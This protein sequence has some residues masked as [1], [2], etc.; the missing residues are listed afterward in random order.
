MLNHTATPNPVN[1]HA[2]QSPFPLWLQHAPGAEMAAQYGYGTTALLAADIQ[3]AI[4]D[5]IP[6]QEKLIKLMFDKPAIL[7]NSPKE[8]SWFE[9]EIPRPALEVL[10]GQGSGATQTIPLT[11]GGSNYISPNTLVHLPSGR[12]AIVTAVDTTAN[13]ITVKAANGSAVLPSISAGQII[14]QGFAPIAD[15]Q[16]FFS[17]Y[18]RLE[19]VEYRNWFATG[20]RARRWTTLTALDYQNNGTTEYFDRDAS[21]LWKMVYEDLFWIFV[22]AEKGQY[23]ITVP[24]GSG[25]TNAGTYKAT[26]GDGFYTFMVKNGAAHS[27]STPAS[28]EADFKT[29]AFGTNH[30]DVDGVR[31]VLGTPRMLNM[32]SDVWKDPVHYAPNDTIAS[33]DLQL[34]HFGAMKFVPLPVHHFESRANLLNGFDKK[35]IVIDKDKIN[36]TAI[37]GREQISANNTG[38]LHKSNGGY[39]DFIDYFIDYNLSTQVET[40]KGH[41]W[42]DMVGV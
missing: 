15:G 40:V 33:L 39:N 24:A 17:N 42:I 12:Q 6:K 10:T 38:S 7:K 25:M 31:Y 9:D 28:L 1:P 26:V 22:N 23:D 30:K 18:S 3:R 20:Q 13:E 29:L 19:L 5:S 36:T 16:N 41:F 2:T 8:Y 34:Y 35:L 11:A 14:T 27:T 21:K 32:M 37:K 4:V